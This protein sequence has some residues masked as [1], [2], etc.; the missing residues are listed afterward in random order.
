VPGALDFI[1]SAVNAD[2]DWGTFIFRAV[3]AH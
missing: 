1:L 2:Q 3:L